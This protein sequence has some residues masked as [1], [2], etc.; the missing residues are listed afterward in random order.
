MFCKCRNCGKKYDDQKSRAWYT[1]YCSQ[2]CLV[3][4]AK[5][6][7][8]N[9]KQGRSQGCQV[10]KYVDGARQIGRVEWN[11]PEPVKKEEPKPI[12]P[13]TRPPTMAVENAIA[14]LAK[15]VAR[16]SYDRA[17]KTLT[18]PTEGLLAIRIELPNS[19]KM[20]ATDIERAARKLLGLP[21]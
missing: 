2:K 15:F 11:D 17:G 7:G 1:G 18:P 19:V 10:Y 4:M 12:V 3:A 20:V 9:G 6:C 16:N 13:P 8:W 21:G 14:I 5:K